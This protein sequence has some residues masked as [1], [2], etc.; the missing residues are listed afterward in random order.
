MGIVISALMV[1][2]AVLF[3]LAAR[4]YVAI[5]DYS[6][7]SYSRVARRRLSRPGRRWS[8]ALP[9][10]AACCCRS[11]RTSGVALASVGKGWALTPLPRGLHAAVLRAGDRGDAQVHRE[12]LPLLRAGR[13]GL[14][15]GRRAH[16]VDARAH[17][18]CRGAARSTRL[19]TL[20]LAMPGTAIGI[21][22]IRAF[23]VTV[24]RASTS[25]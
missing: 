16:R 3:L 25:G 19:N 6:S 17:H 22:Y 21:A 1:V 11:S 4:H 10:A 12:Q 5:K 7:L 2:L 8:I 20:I 23:H 14:R 13:G 9:V 24:A 18:A 15:R